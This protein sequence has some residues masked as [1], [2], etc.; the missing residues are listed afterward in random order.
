[1]DGVLNQSTELVIRVNEAGSEGKELH[2]NS[3]VIGKK[4]LRIVCM[5]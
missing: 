4:S 5:I 2:P 3:H 1:M